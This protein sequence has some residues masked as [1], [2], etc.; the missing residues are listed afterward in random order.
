MDCSE[1]QVREAKFEGLLVGKFDPQS[2][3]DQNR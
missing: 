3:S 1:S 2:I